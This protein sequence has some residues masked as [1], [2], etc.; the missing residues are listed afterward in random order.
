VR[1]N[2]VVAHRREGEP[3]I[4]KWNLKP[5]SG[6]I[7]RGEWLQLQITGVGAV[8]AGIK[9]ALL[10]SKYPYPLLNLGV[11]GSSTFPVGSGVWVEK[12]VEEWSNTT[13]YPLPFATP[14]A[15]LTTICSPG[16]YFPLTDMEG[17]G[18]F[19]GGINFLTSHWIAFFKVVSDTPQ[20]PFNPQ[21][22]PDLIEKNL[23]I[24]E[25]IATFW[26]KEWRVLEEE[27]RVLKEAE[28]L[29]FQFVSHYPNLTHSQR[30]QLRELITFSLLLG[31][32]L[33]SFP[34][35]PLSKKEL[36]T[37]L[38]RWRRELQGE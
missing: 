37:L 34:P 22:V 2:L 29:T 10:L 23:E 26:G 8:E 36:Q 38:T 17:S 1:L 14:S 27:R 19:R 15:P 21:L 12:I 20:I 3:I 31:T 5:E 24:V 11:A 25:R 33:P 32:P 6:N 18:V 28:K 4:K 9:T 13:F 16:E 7:W 30:F 35:P